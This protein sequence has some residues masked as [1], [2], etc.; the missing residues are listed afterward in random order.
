MRAARPAA[1]RASAHRAPPAA[2]PSAG[3]QDRWR[4]SERARSVGAC[5]PKVR[6]GNFSS[7]PSRR[8]SA[9][10][11]R[12]AGNLRSRQGRG[13]HGPK[14][15]LPRDRQPR[16][17]RVIL[18]HDATLGAGAAIGRA[19]D[20]NSP[21]VAC[22]KP[23][24]DVE[25]R[26][27]PA[28]AGADDGEELAAARRACRSARAPRRR[29][30]GRAEALRHAAHRELRGQSRHHGCLSAAAGLMPDGTRYATAAAGARASAYRS[31]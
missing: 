22:S 28:A 13:S 6:A 2:R 12:R 14:A 4:G 16:E 5:R 19:V 8:T 15:I 23:A 9:R 30:L 11:D 27:L 26:R 18:E 21:A 1:I 29:R 3:R 24:S 10:Q 7:E 31:P 20:A 25:Q 17:Q